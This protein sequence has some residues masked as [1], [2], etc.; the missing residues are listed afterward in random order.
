[1]RCSRTFIQ[2]FFKIKILL[3][4]LAASVFVVFAQEAPLNPPSGRDLPD[5]ENQVQDSLQLTQDSIQIT[6]DLP[7]K[8]SD[9]DAEVN[10][11]AQDSI[12]FLRNGRGFFYGEG[13]VKYKDIELSADYIEMD[14]D[15]SL[16]R[17]TGLP[18][19]TGVIAKNPVFKEKDDSFESKEIRYNFKTKKGYILH[20]VTQQGEGFV[21][22]E[23][24]KKM[25]DDVIHMENAR[26]TTCDDTD[27]PHFYLN[28][29]RA[30]VKPGKNIVTG[31]AYLVIEDVPLPIA[32]PFGYFPFSSNYSSGIIVPT[33]G[34]ELTRG[35]YLT[36]GGY[37]FALS[38][39]FDAA[40]TGSIYTK[41]SWGLNLTSRYVK[42]YKFNGNVSI[43]FMTNIY[44]EKDLPDRL[45][46]RD[47]KVFWTH[48]KDSRSNPNL[49]LSASVN[50]AT[51]SYEHNN[52]SGMFDMNQV[53]QNTRSSSVSLTKTFA[54]T[55]FMIS[56]RVNA[57]QITQSATV[58]FVLPDITISMSRVNPFRRKTRI[59][60][61]RWY[62]KISLTYNGRLSN[63]LTTREDKLG[64]TRFP[65]DW[66]NAVQHKIPVQA[67]F[68]VLKYIT[69]TPLVNFTD[70]MYF[71]KVN[72]RWDENINSVVKDTVSTFRN[73]YDY[74]FNVSA[75]TRIFGFFKP[76][77][78][79]G[80]RV[81]M[82]RWVITPT[83][84]Y[85]INPDFG[86]SFFGYWNTYFCPD[87]RP[88][89]EEGAVR[90]V[91][92]SPFANEMFFDVPQL[93]KSSSISFTLSNNVEMK[94]KRERGD[95]IEF[96][97]ISLIENFSANASYNLA[98][99][100]FQLSNINTNLRLRITKSFGISLS[101]AFDPYEYDFDS[102]DNISNADKFERKDAIVHVNRYRW[103]NGRMPQFMG[104]GTSFGYNFSN[105]TFKKKKKEGTA[106]PSPPEGG[107]SAGAS[108]SP[109]SGESE[110]AGYAAFSMPWNLSV[111]YSMDFR[112]STNRED[113]N[114][115]KMQ[116]GYIFTHNI[117][118]SGNLS[119]TPK[120]RINASLAYNISD[121]EITYSTVGITRDLHCWSMTAQFVPI[122]PWRT[123]NFMISVNST[124]LRDLK[125]E[126]RSNPRDN[127]I[128]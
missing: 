57:D 6:P 31:P 4:L 79:L 106:T 119:L 116:F 115:D 34:D 103:S 98:V 24:S 80:K 71:R 28:L 15:S 83:L 63:S 67:S 21:V 69:V 45:V 126:Q 29:T 97:K 104:T 56:G 11:Q 84:T 12:V 125:Y 102:K 93:G 41:G 82:I 42:R 110:G 87:T 13:V 20:T 111:D 124:L 32:L 55:P 105:D 38:D 61:E 19:S 2:H 58:S 64:D 52:L 7:K 46:S 81:D 22:S 99:D 59:G 50:Y 128:W 25:P 53:S 48:S 121:S 113:F 1:M 108:S 40:L 65:Q 3:L 112:R 47:F 92:Y 49:T 120:W 76:L 86:G 66:R 78:F 70:R 30:K 8:R 44:G 17:A 33:F 74:N 90:K 16:V 73:V 123:Y 39:Y 114:V 101:A 35:F 54:G 118:F 72:Q 9:I 88:G 96:K 18:D 26:Y 75:N 5:G 51:T 122:G 94:I 37:Y 95:S 89:A 68:N 60:K 91:F 27:H 36:N 100:S 127:I 23:R 117:S 62:E 109:P 85:G 10:Y 14:V 43:D 77:P 107:E